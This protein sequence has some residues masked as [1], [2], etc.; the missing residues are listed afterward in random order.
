[1]GSLGNLSDKSPLSPDMFI[2]YPEHI[3]ILVSDWPRVIACPEYWA[4]IGQV[5]GLPHP[6]L[7]LRPVLRPESNV[8]IVS[9]VQLNVITLSRGP[10]V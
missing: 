3:R 4:L 6:R 10:G 9:D 8:T 7:R 5:P 1:M 2:V